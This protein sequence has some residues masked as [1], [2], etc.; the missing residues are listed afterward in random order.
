MAASYALKIKPCRAVPV[1]TSPR[2][3]MLFVDDSDVLYYAGARRELR[4]LDRHSANPVIIA[5]DKPWEIEIAWNSVY[6]DHKTGHYQMWYQAYSGKFA[7]AKTHQCAVCYAESDDG[8]H[9]AKPNLG[10]HSYNGIKDTNIVLIGNGG[11]SI[12]YCNSVVVDPIEDDK[13]KRY[14]MAYWDFSQADGRE[15][16]GLS[17]AFSADGIRWTKYPQGALL[18]G[19]YVEKGTPPPFSDDTTGWNIPLSFSDAMDAIYDPKRGEYAIYHKMWIDGPDGNTGWKHAMGR[20]HSKDFIHW[21]NPELLL[22]PDDRDPPSLEFHHSPVFYYG[23]RYFGLLQ[24]LNRAVRGGVIDIELAVSRDGLQ[25]DRPFRNR[26]FLPKNDLKAFDSGN[27]TTNATPVFLEDEFRFYYGGGSEGATSQDVYAVKS[28]IGLATMPRDRF[29]SL[30]AA[31]GTC[32]ITTKP[33]PIGENRLIAL[34]ADAR[35]G[36]IAVELLDGYGRLLK[37]FTKDEAVKLTTDSLN[38]S[39]KWSHG[40]VRQLSAGEYM[41]RLHLSGAAE[42]FAAYI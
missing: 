22:A 8:I 20:T 21:S 30:R 40:D 41:L 3:S 4:P 37:G 24:I 42:L 33:F 35:R 12:N 17:V 27:M 9:W 29:A 14:K 32:Q 23:D 25:W 39:I 6:R 10:I 1:T 26:Y 36:A 34:N 19:S 28:G 38:H 31:H 13:S 2:H 5:R 16:P 11:T 7:K 18:R 15:Y